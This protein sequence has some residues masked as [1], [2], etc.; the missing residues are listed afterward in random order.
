[1][2]GV[3]RSWGVVLLLACPVTAYGWGWHGRTAVRTAYYYP[4]TVVAAPVYVPA[5]ALPA[6][7]YA[8]P[9]P[10]FPAV[11][12]AVVPPGYAC[13]APAPPSGVIAVPAA[14]QPPAGPAPGTAPSANQPGPTAPA[15][16]APPSTGP[17]TSESSRKPADT[18]A[19]AYFD[20]YTVAGSP[21]RPAGERCRVSFWNLAGR[22]LTLKVDGRSVVL[23][24]SK[25]MSFDLGRHFVWRVDDRDPQN[26]TVPAEESGLEIVV[27]R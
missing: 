22:R 5:V 4:V 2:S 17:V 26:E 25:K 20:T 9:P 10:V 23:E 24:A 27:R 13:P 8:P 12:A 7:V 18:A 11:P 14:P 19:S 1:M 15:T 21:D 6:P 16:S 3:L